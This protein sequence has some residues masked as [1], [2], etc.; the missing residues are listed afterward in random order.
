[1]NDKTRNQKARR[2]TTTAQLDTAAPTTLLVPAT[3]LA[4]W[5]VHP[6]ADHLPHSLPDNLD[7]VAIRL[8]RRQLHPVIASRGCLLDGK[9]QIAAGKLAGIDLIVQERDDLTEI[10][11]QNLIVARNPQWRNL[12][13]KRR[14][15]LALSFYESNEHT[16]TAVTLQRAA[17]IFAVGK[18]TLCRYRRHNADGQTQKNVDSM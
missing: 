5:P 8:M 7:H 15:T 17:D 16:E 18:R 2:P 12:S 6:L 13:K 10:E 14:I 11:I 3:E 9:I 1:M 4:E